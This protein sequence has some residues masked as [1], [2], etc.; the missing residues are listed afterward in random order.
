MESQP[1]PVTTIY[2]S[3]QSGFSGPAE[4]VLRDQ[5]SLERAMHEARHDVLVEDTDISVDFD[6]HMVILVALGTRSTGGHG[7]SIDE[8][9]R[10]GD[11]AVV[12]YTVRS[13]A[14]N[15]MTIQVITS[16]V[17]AVSIPRVE[18]SV[19]FERREVVEPC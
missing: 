18:G 2:S 14:P 4:L 6:Q 13:P 12:R 7:I 15:C 5:E 9:E 19:S 3:N 11:G 16:P 8:V 1:L 17:E 10:R